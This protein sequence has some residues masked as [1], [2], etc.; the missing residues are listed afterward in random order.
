MVGAAAVI[1]VG[2]AVS[3]VSFLL[4]LVVLWHWVRRYGS[5]EMARIAV[6]LAA[7]NPVTPYFLAYR[8]AS[9]FFFLSTL[10]L[11]ALS[12][13]RWAMALLWGA[14]ASLTRPT[15]ILL[16]IPYAFAVLMADGVPMARRMVRLLGGLAFA[17]GFIVVGGIDRQVSGNAVAFLK[18]QAAWNRAAGFPFVA[19]LRW[20]HHPGQALAVQGGW[21]FPLL[22]ILFTAVGGLLALWMLKDRALWPWAWYL[23]LVIILA[24]SSNSFEGIPRFI[25]ELPPVYLGLAALA[26][27]QRWQYGILMGVVGLF[28]LYAALWVLGVQAVQ[29]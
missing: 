17:T 23:G 6:L 4:A 27:W 18:F 16:A 26:E 25:A 19:A 1:P 9:L 14:L 13:R 10:S 29:S 24:N 20:L 2:Y 7:F 3:R 8:A 22:A 21:A 28:S 11:W 5:A 15:G 12:C